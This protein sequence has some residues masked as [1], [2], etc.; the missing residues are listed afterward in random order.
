MPIKPPRKGESEASFMARCMAE[1][2]GPDAAD[3]PQEQKVAICLSTYRRGRE[4]Q[5][6]VDL[7]DQ[8]LKW[9]RPS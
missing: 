7:L 9:L 4:R 3:R 5:K 8:A 6:F 2:S 1:L